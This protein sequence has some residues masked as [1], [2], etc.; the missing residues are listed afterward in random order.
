[1][2]LADI[3]SERRARRGDLRRELAALEVE[4]STHEEQRLSYLAAL[5]EERR[6]VEARL[7]LARSR[8]ADERTRVGFDPEDAEPLTWGERVRAA[9]RR[10]AAIDAELA[11]VER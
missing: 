4:G 11:R 2:G 10:L 7:A 1:M 8:P 6:A 9:E 3:I 5:G